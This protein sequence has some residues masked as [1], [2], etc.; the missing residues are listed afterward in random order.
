LGLGRCETWI[1][2]VDDPSGHRI[3]PYLIFFLTE[4]LRFPGGSAQDR[5]DGSKYLIHSEKAHAE[6]AV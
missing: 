6:I 4:Q 3:R 5:A 2:M 1:V